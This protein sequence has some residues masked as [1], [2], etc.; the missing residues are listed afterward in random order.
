[1]TK[2]GLQ[3]GLPW[4]PTVNTYWRSIVVKGRPRV[5]ISKEGR[6][7]RE[8][9][10]NLLAGE[11]KDDGYFDGERLKVH[12]AAMPPDRRSR[13]LDNILKSLLDSMQHAGVFRDD[14]QI[15]YLAVERHSV[16]LLRKGGVIVTVEEI[17]P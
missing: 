7:Y 17:K 8:K 10:K 9:V 16:A 13:D 12:I 1:M 14:S 5:L 2:M 4:P 11:I 15:D 3:I 6:A